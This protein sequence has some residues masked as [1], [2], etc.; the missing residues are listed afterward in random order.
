MVNLYPKQDIARPVK[1]LIHSS[2]NAAPAM[3]TTNKHN[4]YGYHFQIKLDFVA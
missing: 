3:V 2:Q 4:E 1:I